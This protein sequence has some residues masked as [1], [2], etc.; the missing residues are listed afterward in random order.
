MIERLSFIRFSPFELDLER[1]NLCNG[2]GPIEIH[3]T[4]LRLLI[5]LVRHRDRVVS[6]TELLD[7]VWSDAYVSESAIS[8]AVN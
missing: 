5:H 2:A 6:K 7:H 3:A 8:S 4:P 1:P